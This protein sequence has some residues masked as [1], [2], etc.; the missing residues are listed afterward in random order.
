MLRTATLSGLF[1]L[2]CQQVM[3][4][5]HLLSRAY[6][7]NDLARLKSLLEQFE[8]TLARGEAA[9]SPAGYED[10]KLEEA[11]Q[12]Q[13]GTEWDRDRGEQGPVSDVRGPE[14]GYQ[15]RRSRLEDLLLSTRRK[16]PSTCFGARM[17]RIG[18]YSGLGCTVTKG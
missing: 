12:G 8:E 4:T 6:S 15:A 10:G 18:T 9:A 2:L 16:S 1:V 3:V 7:V 17:D 13:P 11:E 5:A 14:D